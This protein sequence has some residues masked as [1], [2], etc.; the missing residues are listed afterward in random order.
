M[1]K[2]NYVTVMG[3]LTFHRNETWSFWNDE[4]PNI[5]VEEV[6]ALTADGSELNYINQ[7]FRNIPSVSQTETVTWRGHL[8]NL[9]MNTFKY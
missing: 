4:K 2:V 3:K 9:F 6:T 8:R 7:Y 1:F 5:P